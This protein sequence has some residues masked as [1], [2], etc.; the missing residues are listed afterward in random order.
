MLFN[1]AETHI[2]QRKIN[3]DSFL[4]DKELGLYIVADGVGGLDKGEIASK[5]ACETIHQ[6]ITIGSSLEDAVYNA[7]L[8]IVNEIKNDEDKK[9]M[10]TTVVA[11]L[12][13]NNSYEIAW[14]GDSRA[15]TWNDELQL[16]T[17]DDSYVE[18]L[19]ENGHIGI[20]DLE[21]HPDRNVISQALG[22]ERKNI[23]VNLN[24]GTL[25]KNQLLMICSDGL[26][27]IANEFDII[28]TV[29]Q[30]TDV[31]EVSKTLVATSVA[32]GGRDNITLLTLKTDDDSSDL[33]SLV[34]PKVYRKFDSITG[35]IKGSSHDESQL[36]VITIDDGV[37]SE[38]FNQTEIK[39]LTSD[40]LNLLNS[41]AFN[42]PQ[43]P[44]KE[45]NYILQLIVFSVIIVIGFLIFQRF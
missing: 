12:F 4:V 30:V 7:H 6:K 16:I 14:V 35:K 26:Y 11:V 22:I 38:L 3:E 17:R 21:T 28:K 44:H 13:T 27:T 25:S 40:E 24:S 37:D 29:S 19:L 20:H 18:L 10:A 15:Y 42:E 2:G 34:T 32:K 39:D 43:S 36:N 31:E 5:L 1:F 8:A 23:K 9:G 45:H 33:N 41:T